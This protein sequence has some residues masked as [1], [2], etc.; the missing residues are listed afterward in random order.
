MTSV[1][2]NDDATRVDTP[3]ARGGYSS[4]FLAAISTTPLLKSDFLPEPADPARLRAVSAGV[5]EAVD[6]T[7]REIKEISDEEAVSLG[8]VSLLKDRH[9]RGVLRQSE[10]WRLCAAAARNGDLEEL[11]ALHVDEWPWDA[12][13]CA[14]A[15]KGGH[16]RV[17]QWLRENDCPWSEWTCT[18]AAAGGHLEVLKWA[19]ANDCPWSEATCW[20]AAEHKRLEILKWALAN[21]APFDGDTGRK[22]REWSLI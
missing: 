7:G 13:T 18:S 4:L 1:T 8:Y 9:S 17:L 12:R 14:Y 5:R 2:S 20:W 22:L 10:G 11:K 19:R 6:A 15:A 3:A 21:G 16:L